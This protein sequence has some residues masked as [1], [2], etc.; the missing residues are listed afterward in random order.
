MSTPSVYAVGSLSGAYNQIRPAQNV[1]CPATVQM[2]QKASEVYRYGDILKLTSGTVERV[3]DPSGTD[4]NIVITAGTAV[5]YCLR[6]FTAASSVTV[7]DTVPCLRLADI[8]ILVRLVSLTATG[9]A[10]TATGSDSEQRDWTIGSSYVMG[11]HEI[12]TGSDNYQLVM[13][14]ATSS[15]SWKIVE[16]S[17]ESAADDDYGL[18]WVHVA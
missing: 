6:S 3:I 9:L 18:A 1:L 16:F 14:A 10:S 12:G 15:G 7:S 17:K 2:P 13:S 4:G 11:I 5:Y 8:D